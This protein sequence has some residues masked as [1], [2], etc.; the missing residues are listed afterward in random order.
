LDPIQEDTSIIEVEPIYLVPVLSFLGVIV[1][2]LVILGILLYRHRR[3]MEQHKATEAKYGA[4]Q[5]DDATSKDQDANYGIHGMVLK[6]DAKLQAKEALEK[7]HTIASYIALEHSVVGIF[8]SSVAADYGPI[9]RCSVLLSQVSVGCFVAALWYEHSEESITTSLI[10]AAFALL[11]SAAVY[12]SSKF[13]FTREAS[14]TNDVSELQPHVK[15]D[16]TSRLRL[17]AFCIYAL[18]CQMILFSCYSTTLLAIHF[19][20]AQTMGWFVSVIMFIAVSMLVLEPTILVVYYYYE[21]RYRPNEHSVEA[22]Q[23]VS[24]NIDS[25]LEQ[26]VVQDT[27]PVP[28]E[29]HQHDNLTD[30][31][32]VVEGEQDISAVRPQRHAFVPDNVDIR[33]SYNPMM[34][35]ATTVDDVIDTPNISEIQLHRNAVLD[36]NVGDAPQDLPPPE[37][38]SSPT[39]QGPPVVFRPITPI[40]AQTPFRAQTPAQTPAPGNIPISSTPGSSLPKIIEDEVA[41][42]S[43]ISGSVPI[44]PPQTPPAAAIAMA[45]IQR[46]R[47]ELARAKARAAEQTGSLGAELGRLAPLRPVGQ[48]LGGVHRLSGLQSG[49]RHA[50]SNSGRESLVRGLALP[51]FARNGTLVGSQGGLDGPPTLSDQ[52][53]APKFGLPPLGSATRALPPELSNLTSS[54]RSSQ[55]NSEGSP[56]G[57]S[58]LPQDSAR[59]FSRRSAGSS[60][61]A[62]TGRF[63]NRNSTRSQSPDHSGR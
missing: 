49:H 15:R 50:A 6:E 12:K 9:R 32:N 2:L 1:G 37:P 34:D 25:V 28:E 14:I 43:T 24:N 26:D 61:P 63:S 41:L 42:P 8:K 11:A 31:S 44:S 56:R 58:A 35:T 23:Q 51:P 40:R 30:V 46:M 21:I 52:R 4:E 16:F 10:A 45:E 13:L 53:P 18:Q 47:Q 60:S 29:E 33:Q 5:V 38:V 55:G 17:T 7:D 59:R 62:R 48:P 20:S 57:L 36:T 22:K 39:V 3:H 54:G 19:E 27:K